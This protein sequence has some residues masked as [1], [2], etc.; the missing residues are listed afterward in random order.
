MT[1]DLTTSEKISV[2]QRLKAKIDAA[3]RST[4]MEVYEQEIARELFTGVKAEDAASVLEMHIASL[5]EEKVTED[6]KATNI[7]P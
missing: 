7:Q 4:A 2:A 3:A 1:Y 6:A 5:E